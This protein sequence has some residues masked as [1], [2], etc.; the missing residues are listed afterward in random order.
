QWSFVPDRPAAVELRAK[1]RGRFFVL[2][3]IR[4]IVVKVDPMFLE[5]SVDFYPRLEAQ[6]LTQGG[7]RKQFCSIA[8]QGQGLKG[9]TGWILPFGSD[10]VRDMDCNLHRRR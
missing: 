3:Q 6:H 5:K 1:P 10:F 4:D 2:L 9:N 7:L 8:F